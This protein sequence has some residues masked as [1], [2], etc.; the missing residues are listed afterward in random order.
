VEAAPSKTQQQ[1]LDAAFPLIRK[2][3]K[4]WQKETKLLGFNPDSVRG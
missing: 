2:W 4:I 3:R 1:S